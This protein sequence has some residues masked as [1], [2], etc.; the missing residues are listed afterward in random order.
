LQSQ[1]LQE[2]SEQT[3]EISFHTAAYVLM[4][5]SGIWLIEILDRQLISQPQLKVLRKKR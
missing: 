1:P 3:S 4:H 5:H 2:L